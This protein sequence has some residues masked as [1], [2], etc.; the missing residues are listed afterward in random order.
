[1]EKT[2]RLV[3][4]WRKG[5]SSGNECEERKFQTTTG[6]GARGKVLS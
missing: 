3:A 6:Q 2:V 4:V 5:T 1:M